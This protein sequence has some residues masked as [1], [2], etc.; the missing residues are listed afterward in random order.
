MGIAWLLLIRTFRN[1]PKRTLLFL[2]GYALATT[3][4]ITLLSV[5][6][7]VLKQAQDKDLLGG[8]DLI[9]VP[10]GIDLES[11]K[12]GGITA[13]YY[14]I[15]QG[16]FLVRQ[17]LQSSRFVSEIAQVS[18]YIF[19]R[20]LYARKSATPQTA[21]IFAQ[22]S[23]PDEENRVKGTTAPWRNTAE[24]TQWL[25]PGGPE[26]YHDIDR[27][28]LPSVAGA[29]LQH[30][31]EWH[32]F[33]FESADF[34]GYL[35]L[36]VS[37]D[38]TRDQAQWIVSLQII[39]SEYNRYSATYPAAREQLPLQRISYRAGG[40]S[41]RFNQDHYEIDVDFYDR[42]PIKG[43]LKYFPQPGLY[44]PPTDLARSNHFESG[45]VIP[46]I[47]GA[48]DGAITIG[49]KSYR[50]DGVPGYHD[51]NW[52]IWQEIIWNWGHLYSNQYALFFGE[53]FLEGKSKGLFVGLLDNKG[54]LTLLRPDKIKFTDYK[55]GPAGTLVP[56]QWEIEAKKQFASLLLRGKA[57]SFV[58][59]KV[60]GAEPLYFIQYKANYRVEATL[61]NKKLLFD[62]TGNAETFVAPAGS[63]Q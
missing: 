24:D 50:F 47:R 6:E 12:M 57:Q 3:V 19:S 22:G 10:Q 52:G 35:S 33:N 54:F 53:I 26:F 31:A 49:N 41:V 9:L 23:F 40:T 38:I 18:P 15:P 25:H 20:L 39:D 63:Y 4:M 48:Y 16:R 14:S 32:Y 11:M 46:A 60:E 37:G 7:A 51:H 56:M 55:E 30:W 2:L 43:V 27:F 42:V 62:A 13:L 21:T 8:G 61:D 45:Y 34:H 44:F 17:L 36:M 5:G 28:H 58:S 59:T 29:D 1:R